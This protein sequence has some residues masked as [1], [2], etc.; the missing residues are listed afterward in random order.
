MNKH[1]LLLAVLALV[2]QGTSPLFAEESGDKRISAKID[3]R[4]EEEDLKNLPEDSS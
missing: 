2:F 4:K 1:A 3:S